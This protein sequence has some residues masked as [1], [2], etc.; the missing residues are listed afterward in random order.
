MPCVAGDF[1]AS[2]NTL[3]FSFLNPD[4]V[5][6][7]KMHTN[8]PVAIKFVCLSSFGPSYPPSCM[9]QEPRKSDAPQLRDEFRSYRTLNGTCMSL[10]INSH[11]TCSCK[12]AGIPQVHYFGQEGLHN[13]LVIDLLGPN[14]EDLFDMCGRK[15]TIKTVCMAAKQMVGVTSFIRITR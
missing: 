2:L 9:P 1:S 15:F 7:V 12:T 6:G 13:V 5:T 8:T 11:V 10:Y 14:L 3:Q 4:P